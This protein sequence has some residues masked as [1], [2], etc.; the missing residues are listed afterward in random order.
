LQDGASRAK[1]VATETLAR[2]KRA[3]LG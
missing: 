2:V 1:H 3:M